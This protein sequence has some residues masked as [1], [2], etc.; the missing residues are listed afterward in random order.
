VKPLVLCLGNE[1]LGDDGAGMLVARKLKAT[2]GH[3]SDIIETSLSGLSLIEYFIGY[4]QAIIVDAIHTGNHPPGTVIE[5]YPDQL[6]SVIAPSPHYAGLPEMLELAKSLDVEFPEDIAIFAIEVA[7]P[8][9][10]GGAID[11]RVEKGIDEAVIKIKA[12]LKRWQSL[13]FRTAARKKIDGNPG[14]VAR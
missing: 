5:L 3:G 12:R 2:Q 4:K 7:D 1:L 10:I 13:T 11:S 9:T 14:T 6:R 8:Y